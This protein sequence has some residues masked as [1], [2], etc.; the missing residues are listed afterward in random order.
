MLNGSDAADQV[1][2][3]TLEGAEVALKISGLAA[4]NVAAYLIAVLNENKK[5]RG[6]AGIERM[7][8]EGKPIKLFQIPTDQ[9]KAFAKESKKYGF[10]FY[11][12]LDKRN[13][14]PET[15]LMVFAK[16]A[17]KVNRVLDKLSFAAVD[18]GA[19]E[20]E[21]MERRNKQ[22]PFD[23][24]NENPSGIF[25]FSNNSSQLPPDPDDGGKDRKSIRQA[26]EEI[27]QQGKKLT[28][29]GTQSLTQ[30]Q[31][32]KLSKRK[33]LPKMKAR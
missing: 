9:L 5:T 2:R 33:K 18:T 20:S 11:A 30:S 28:I 8:R 31:P 27:R 13:P 22:S 32:H 25:S 17:A 23:H 10:L 15:D 7:L 24:E 16:D 1:V 6:R 4:K 29:K 14:A 21:A 26:L 3:Y 19:I 12:M